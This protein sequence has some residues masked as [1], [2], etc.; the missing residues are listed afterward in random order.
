MVF[1]KWFFPTRNLGILRNCYLAFRV[2]SFFKFK[3]NWL[4]EVLR[5]ALLAS[6]LVLAAFVVP[7]DFLGQSS[8]PYSDAPVFG[9]PYLGTHLTRELRDYGSQPR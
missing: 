4:E 5:G 3:R 9:F 1:P 7:D 2:K 8:T 6:N